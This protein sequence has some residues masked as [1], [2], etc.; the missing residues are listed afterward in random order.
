MKPIY[1][2]IIIVV[3][4][5]GCFYG[6]MKVGQNNP[7]MASAL[8][9]LTKLRAAGGTAGAGGFGGFAGRTGAGG[10]TGGGATAGQI[11]SENGQ[12]ITL[13]L[14]SG[15]SE[16]VFVSTTTA[17]MKTTSGSLSDLA[18]GDNV[19]VIGT[20]NTDGSI[21]AES[22]QLRPAGAPGT[23]TSSTNG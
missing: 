19:T 21:T 4:A 12:T 13:Q 8:A 5:A 18:V 7:T 3:I 1:W 22:I 6:G 20:T 17:V 10:T 14:R 9:A 15:S 23:A 11:V 2:I 16:N